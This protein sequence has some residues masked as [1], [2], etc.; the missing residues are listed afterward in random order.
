MSVYDAWKVFVSPRTSVAVLVAVAVVLLLMVAMPQLSVVGPQEYV[1][2]LDS[3]GP[4]TRF[5]LERL[6]LGQLSTHPAFLGLLALFFA[7]LA[8]VLVVRAGP[9]WRRTALR[10]L[11]AEG[12]RAWARLEE[13]RHAPLPAD[14]SAGRAAETLRG[15]GYR[16]RR[17]DDGTLW[18]VKHRLAPLGF[19]LFHASF[20]LICA[21]AV[22][23]YYTRFRGTVYLSEGQEFTGQYSSVERMPPLGGPPDLRF[24]VQDVDPRMERGEPV[25]LSARLRFDQPGA[26]VVRESQ[27]NYP[28]TWGTA[29]LLVNEAGLAPALWLQDEQG[30]TLDRTVV[31]VPVSAARQPTEVPLAGGRFTARLHAL[32]EGTPFPRREERWAAALRVEVLGPDRAA[33]PLFD[34]LVSKRSPAAF[35]G[36]R[37]V[38]TEVRYWVGVMV[39]AERG[40][41][42]LI[43]GFTLG[44][45]GLIWRLLLYRRE[46]AVAWNS[47]E[48][49]LVGRCE[50]F[51]GAFQAELDALRD[52][53]VAETGRTGDA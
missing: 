11:H 38:M 48:V 49:R 34:G 52:A 15:F 46:V 24:T 21:G 18:G 6:G 39:V 35:P 25:G 47:Q 42:L 10:P 20:F 50:Y 2:T 40:G 26:P 51:S 45:V 53:L 30:F 37:L 5:L 23:V 36:G 32:A 16:V 28:A 19:L 12:L 41:G 31:P 22:L 4:F 8:A 43:A 27:V 29:S 44:T 13:S 33:P 3:G 9:T 7:H 17:P 14:W 1:E